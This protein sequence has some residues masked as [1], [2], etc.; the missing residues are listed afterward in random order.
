MPIIQRL[1]V[2]YKLWHSYFIRLDKIPRYSIGLRIDSLFL[3]TIEYIFTASNKNREQKFIYLNKAS[4]DFDLLKFLLQIAWQIDVLAEN[5]YIALSKD[6]YEI[7]K[8]L[9]G[10]LKQYRPK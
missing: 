7:G 3:E 1:I 4:E 2:V 8:M 9:G 10:W 6:L 5:K